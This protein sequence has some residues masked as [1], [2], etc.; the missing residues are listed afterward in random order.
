MNRNTVGGTIYDSI[1][2]KIA[3]SKMPASKRYYKDAYIYSHLLAA[4]AGGIQH[5][6]AKELFTH[7]KKRYKRKDGEY[8][9][10]GGNLVLTIDSRLQEQ[11]FQL[12]QKYEEATLTLVNDKGAIKAMAST[13][14]FDINTLNREYNTL[15]K[16]SGSLVNPA[17]TP[18][19]VGSVLK[20][21]IAQILVDLGYDFTID[22]RGYAHM[23]HKTI[24]NSQGIA[25]GKLNLSRALEV[26]SNQFFIEAAEYLGKNSI[27]SRFRELAIGANLRVDFGMTRSRMGECKSKYDLARIVI[28]QDVEISPL[29][30]T[31]VAKAIVTGE[32][33]TPFLINSVEK[34]GKSIQKTKQGMLQG[35]TS[36]APET[37]K[38][39]NGMMV[40]CAES[41]GL[42]EESCGTKVIAKTGT[43]ELSNGKNIAVLMTAWPEVHPQYYMVIQVR[44]EQLFGKDLV[45]IAKPMIRRLT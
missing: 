45:G 17:M 33:K 25:Y 43:A 40:S 29:Q 37:I 1:G 41:Y 9:Y 20:P 13:P 26:S 7:G 30:L 28:G 8:Y 19:P 5:T 27:I 22:D 18:A 39:V 3:F 34:D 32:I 24:Q 31:M 35:K 38:S 11:A 36:A 44:N 10:K 15:V 23:D 16:K 12:I 42:S 21:V 6:Y 14:S 2:K 4:P